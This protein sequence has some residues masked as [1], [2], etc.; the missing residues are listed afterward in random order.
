M[1]RS[2]KLLIL[3]VLLCACAGGY[4]LVSGMDGAEQVSEETGDFAL[5]ARTAEELT[6]LEWA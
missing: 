3:L 6:G 4:L 1:K 2:I 5:T